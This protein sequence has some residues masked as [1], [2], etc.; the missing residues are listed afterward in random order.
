[1]KVFTI[2]ALQ[3]IGILSAFPVT[4][5][6]AFY[7]LAGLWSPSMAWL[8]IP[9]ALSPVALAGWWALCDRIGKRR[10]AIT[11]TLMA[12]SPTTLVA[13]YLTARLG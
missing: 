1:M 5:Y 9:F 11:A 12:L 10:R 13:L 6:L 3:F 8:Q 4:L 2:K 7:A